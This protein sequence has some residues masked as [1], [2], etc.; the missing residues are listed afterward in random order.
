MPLGRIAEIWRYPVSGLQGERLVQG[1]VLKMG[2][3]GDHAYVL[4][5]RDGGK[6]L[7]PIS[8]SSSSV[9]REGQRG[10]LELAAILSGDPKGEHD[11]VIR[12]AGITIYSSK[13]PDDT[14]TLSDALGRS[15]ELV[16]YPR[17][18]ESRVRAGRALHLLTDFS[19]EQ[20]RRAYP[21][22]EF[23]A[24][25]FR[26]NFLMAV[27]DGVSGC[28]EEGWIGKDLDLG[29]QARLHVEKA[30]VRCKMTAM[31][32][33]GMRE[34]EGILQA[35][36]HENSNNLGVMCAVLREGIVRVGDPVSLA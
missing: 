25:R 27:E 35:I 24:R 19:L 22:G 7:D 26:P 29:G 18:V 23:D 12:T 36:R 5:R 21:A 1:E 28:V 34:D 30:N 11:V 17:I 2:I 8:H 15:V 14:E 33:A 6:V 13:S 20:M 32:Q 16:R 3:A 4:R 10:M 9:E 31:K